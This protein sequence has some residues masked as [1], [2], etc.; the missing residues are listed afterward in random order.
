MIP[1]LIFCFLFVHV[2]LE[3]VASVELACFIFHLASRV[4]PT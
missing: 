3:G 1:A 2:V 4:E